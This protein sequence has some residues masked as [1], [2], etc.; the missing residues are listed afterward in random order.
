MLSIATQLE[1]Q[2][3]TAQKN[4]LE[5]QILQNSSARR[6]LLNSPYFTGGLARVSAAEA[7]FGLNNITNETQLM[8]V[9]AE[10][11][12]LNNSGSKLNYLA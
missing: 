9:N 10:L 11:S 3:L 8:L 7:S 4:N 12:K 1:K 6:S 5:F 2:N